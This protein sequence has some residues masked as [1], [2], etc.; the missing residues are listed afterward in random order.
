MPLLLIFVG[1]LPFYSQSFPT[2]TCK[3]ERAEWGLRLGVKA[4][5]SGWDPE[6]QRYGKL[7][8]DSFVL[9]TP[10]P[11]L[12]NSNSEAIHE[13]I[14]PPISTELFAFYSVSKTTGGTRGHQT[15]YI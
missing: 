10:R 5:L 3:A 4:H 11:D 12:E 14:N 7:A 6:N 1:M 9:S 13:F 15:L 8:H 2:N